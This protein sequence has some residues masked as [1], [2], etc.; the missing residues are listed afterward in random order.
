MLVRDDAGE[1]PR[2]ALTAAA[3]DGWRDVGDDGNLLAYAGR[4]VTIVVVAEPLSGTVTPAVT[5]A[6]LQ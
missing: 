2:G 6:W 5:A 3:T 1:T 4:T